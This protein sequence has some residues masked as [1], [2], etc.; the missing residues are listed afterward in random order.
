MRTL[1]ATLFLFLIVAG[2]AGTGELAPSATTS[3]QP[4]RGNQASG[5]VTFSQKGDKVLVTAKVTG[6]SP[7]LHGFHVH[8]KGDCSAADGTSAGPHFN[9]TGVPHGSPNSVPHHGGD[10]GNLTADS[11]GNAMLSMEVSGISLDPTA[12]NSIVGRSV[13]VHANPDDLKSQPAGNSGP[14]IACGVIHLVE[15]KSGSSGY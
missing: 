7:G 15:K 4:T 10:L 6:L 1:L 5:T 3:L 12:A 11:L 14:R 9:P 2:C 8:E 13:I